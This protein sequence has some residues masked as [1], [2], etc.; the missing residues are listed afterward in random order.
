MSMLLK[1]F[2]AVYAHGVMDWLI[3]KLGGKMSLKK[4]TGMR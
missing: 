1:E 4:I 3:R 2:D